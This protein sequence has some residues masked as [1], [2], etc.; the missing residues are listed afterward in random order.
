MF[1]FTSYRCGQSVENNTIDETQSRVKQTDINNTKEIFNADDVIL[2]TNH[3]VEL[4]VNVIEVKLKNNSGTPVITGVDYAVEH[5]RDDDW[6]EIPLHYAFNSIGIVV[7]NGN[8]RHFKIDLQP[9][10]HKYIQ[11]LYRVRKPVLL[12]NKQQ[13]VYAQFE[14]NAKPGVYM[15]IGKQVI[16]I[17]VET[18]GV[19]VINNTDKDVELGNIYYIEKREADKWNRIALDR[20]TLGNIIAYDLVGYS[21]KPNSFIKKTY[22]L[23]KCAYNYRAGKYRIVI[24]YTQSGVDR[25][26]SSEFTV[27]E[28]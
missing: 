10:R 6:K 14:I 15:E 4:P 22:S 1:C 28:R 2:Y 24:P 16:P 8:V 7:P 21:L 27:A 5:Y 26:M 11:G 13:Y 3:N 25:K 20:D 17:S 23:L 9:E 12:G 18:L 19:T